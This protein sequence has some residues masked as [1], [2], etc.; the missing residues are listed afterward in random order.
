VIEVAQFNPNLAVQ[1]LTLLAIGVFALFVVV[2]AIAAVNAARRGRL[3][4]VAEV[5]GGVLIGV[6]ILGLASVA[7]LQAAGVDVWKWLGVFA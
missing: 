3:K 6:L 7:G 1:R 4:K 5:A 2:A